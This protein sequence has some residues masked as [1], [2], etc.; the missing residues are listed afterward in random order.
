MTGTQDRLIALIGCSYLADLIARA[1]DG[2]LADAGLTD[3]ERALLREFLT[4]R[5]TLDGRLVWPVGELAGEA[6]DG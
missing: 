2:Y 3:A 5:R 1:R 6:A 4:P